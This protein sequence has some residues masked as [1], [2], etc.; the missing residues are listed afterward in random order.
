MSLEN[1]MAG[2]LQQAAQDIAGR[3][4]SAVIEIVQRL[5]SDLNLMVYEFDKAN[6]KHPEGKPRPVFNRMPCYTDVNG[7][8]HMVPE[9]YDLSYT[10]ITNR[11]W[12]D[13]YDAQNKLPDYV[14]VPLGS[15][16]P[17]VDLWLVRDPEHK[18]PNMAGA[19]ALWEIIK[20]D[21]MVKTFNE[22]HTGT[23]NAAKVVRHTTT[24]FKFETQQAL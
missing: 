23:K 19:T 3:S 13:G 24:H 22:F 21:C 20:E 10:L 15:G 17:F 16:A 5:S 4:D 1:K 14:G 6:E 18:E 2:L 9:G 11:V 7:H 12:P 8:D